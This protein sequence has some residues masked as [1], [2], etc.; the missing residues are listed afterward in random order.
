MTE[1]KKWARHVRVI[2]TGEEFGS[3]RKCCAK[4]KLDYSDVY[5]SLKGQKGKIKG[6]SFEY[7]E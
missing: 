6:Y 2:E 4:L 5:K 1:W 7:V 3:V